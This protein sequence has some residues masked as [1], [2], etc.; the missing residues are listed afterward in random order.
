MLY[1]VITGIALPG[2]RIAQPERAGL[3]RAEAQIEARAPQA[4]V[5][6][7]HRREGAQLG[8]AEIEAAADLSYNFV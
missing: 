7:P 6:R 1:E 3:A 2:D 5:A 4:L 8:P